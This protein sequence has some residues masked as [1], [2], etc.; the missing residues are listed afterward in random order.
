MEFFKKKTYFDF[1]AFRRTA[2][3]ISIILLV[4]SVGSLVIRGINWGL[5]FTGGTLIE[6]HYSK[7]A[8][9]EKIR[10]A[11]ATQKFPDAVVMA[12]GTSSDVMVRIAPR[13]G[14][15]EQEISKNILDILK[16]ENP[17][18]KLMR[19]D[20]IG[21]KVGRE[22]AEQGG[23]ALLMALLLIAFYIAFRFEYRFAVSAAVGLAH[24]PILILGVFSFFQIEF[25]L[26]TLAAILAVIGYSLNDTI[27]V[28]DRIK[29][30]FIKV[31]KA[32]TAEIVNRSINETLSRTVITSGSTL[33]VVLA[34]L[35]L[36]G[37][38]I[39]GFALALCIGIVVGTYSSV[40][41]ASSLAMA[42]GLSRKDLIRAP[43]SEVDDRP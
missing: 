22:L 4:F 27:V 18:V 42:M 6:L 35:I 17:D 8:D 1:V 34:L 24:D 21:A 16:T 19:I 10:Q 7:P 32:T 31:R 12:Y 14:M 13:E 11:L 23:L 41:I 25:D 15:T 36:G 5:D 40:Y 43:K 9:L 30:N 2:S 26:N 33:M 38:N 20:A 28:Y 37:Q 3:I 29:E 39:H